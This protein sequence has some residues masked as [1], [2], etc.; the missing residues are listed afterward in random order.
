MINF[1]KIINPLKNITDNKTIDELLEITRDGFGTNMTRE[2]VKNH[3]LNTEVLYLIKDKEL[4]G[5]SSYDY[6]ILAGEKSIYLNGIVVKRNSQKKGVFLD[7]NKQVIEENFD[8]KYLVMRTQ[9]PV[10]YGATKKLV[11]KIY[12]S[13]DEIPKHIIN[14]GVEASKRLNMKDFNEQN[15][16]GRNTYGT[17][18]YDKIPKHS[19]SND[20]FDNFLRINYE[21]GDSIIIVGEINGNK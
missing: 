9:N 2:D 8:K 20:F 7:L 16:V 12:P 14:I 17:C 4:I 6:P 3:V 10:I 18:L 13:E 21:K 5:F 15:F 1:E 19:F 11:D